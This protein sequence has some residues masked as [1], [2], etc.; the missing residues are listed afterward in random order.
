MKKTTKGELIY[1]PSDLVRYVGSPFASWMDR[2]HLENPEAV[3][4]DEDTESERLIAQTGQEHERTVLAELKAFSTGLVE[5]QTRD[6]AVARSQTLDAIKAKAPIIYQAILHSGQFAGYA[7]FLMLDGAEH[8]QV[9]D[10]KL[11]H[12]PKPYYAIQL[13][14][15]ADMLAAMIGEHVSDRFGIILG[16]KERLEFRLEDFVHY[17]RQINK[18]FLRMQEQFTGRL[19]DRPEPLPR[20]DHY[21]WTSHA[22]EFFK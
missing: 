13:C 14:C 3:S 20:A 1:S 2:Y 15:Y 5:I 6:L 21:Q 12:S 10:T 9:W 11:A 17:Y 7:D 22:Q 8:Y 16:T 19:S 18:S 4:P